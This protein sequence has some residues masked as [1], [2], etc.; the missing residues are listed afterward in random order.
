MG[1]GG[2]RASY[3]LVSNRALAL[4]WSNQSP[5][6]TIVSGG[7]DALRHAAGI[8]R[9]RNDVATSPKRRRSSS[10][11]GAEPTSE[12]CKAATSAKTVDASSRK[13][14]RSRSNISS[15]SVGGSGASV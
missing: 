2:A 15:N 7:A 9:R 8:S 1:L 13:R 5:S 10:L 4:T 6:D 3:Q 12:L 11:A 14:P